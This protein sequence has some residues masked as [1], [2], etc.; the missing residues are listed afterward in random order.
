MLRLKVPRKPIPKKLTHDAII[1]AVFEMRFDM[2]SIPEVLYGRLA[3]HPAWKKFAQRRLPAYELPAVLRLADENLRY[4]PVFELVDAVGNRSIR[5]GPQVLSYHQREPY[6]GGTEFQR[7]LREA[8]EQFFAKS[9]KL[10]IRR[11]GLR[12]LNALRPQLH[13]GIRGVSDID[14]SIIVDGVQITRS[15]NLNY[16]TTVG[17][18][19]C[20]TVRVATP[21]FVQG[22]YPA[23]TALVIDVDMF[24]RENFAA[25]DEQTVTQWL[26]RAREAEKESFFS[27]LKL[28]TIEALREE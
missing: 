28:Q 15:M 5:I 10:T 11:L 21:D 16:T 22:S 24:T 27:L 1:E 9:D 19:V 7:N 2:A 20:C 17:N 18:D 4:Q 3:D 14:M 25:S 23:E 8:V 6:V 12:Y 13:G 26:S